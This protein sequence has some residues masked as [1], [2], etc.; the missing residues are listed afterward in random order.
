MEFFFTD[1]SQFY[2]VI[3]VM[4][5]KRRLLEFEVSKFSTKNLE[6]FQCFSQACS[7]C[8]RSS[9]CQLD[10]EMVLFIALVL[11]F[12]LHGYF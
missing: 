9:G 7:S 11:N 3:A 8:F 4:T 2:L 6:L 12:I 1:I 10:I 5:L